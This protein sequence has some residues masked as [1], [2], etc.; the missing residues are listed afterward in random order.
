MPS[1]LRQRTDTAA[2]WGT[3]DPV[4]RNKQLCFDSTNNIFKIGNGVDV[5]SALPVQSGT[6]GPTGSVGSTGL[7]G[8]TGAPALILGSDTIANILAKPDSEGD[9]WIATDAGVDDNSDPVA[10]GDGL[11][12]LGNLWVNIGQIKGD[13]GVPGAGTVAGIVGGVS[14]SIEDSDPTNPIVNG[15]PINNTLT[16]DSATEVLSAQ[17]GKKLETEKAPLASPTFTGTVTAPTLNATALGSDVDSASYSLK[18]SSY[19]QQGDATVNGAVVF[20]YATGDMIQA[21]ASSDITS[22]AFTGFPTGKVC[23]MI[24]DA[25]N[26]GSYNITH[27]VG[28]LYA[29]GEVPEYT[30][31]G[32]DRILITK[33]KDNIYTLTVIG[34]DIKVSA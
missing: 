28:M 5:F 22:M 13:A 15:A 1:I 3:I 23:A 33:D 30:A 6:A 24:I 11:S 31:V 7:T 10:V 18:E 27:L 26:W 9:I 14:I 2:A 19:I 34:L 21:T 32:T 8:D 17:Q 4:I 16:S 20:N 29:A 12:S 25:V